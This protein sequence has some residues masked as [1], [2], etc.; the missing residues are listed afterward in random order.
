MLRNPEN[1]LVIC[2]RILDHHSWEFAPEIVFSAVSLLPLFFHFLSSNIFLKFHQ[3]F[4]RNSLLQQATDPLML[5]SFDDWIVR[6]RSSVFEASALKCAKS[7]LLFLFRIPR[8]KALILHSI[9]WPVS[10]N[11][12]SIWV[13]VESIFLQVQLRVPYFFSSPGPRNVQ[14]LCENPCSEFEIQISEFFLFIRCHWTLTW[15]WFYLQYPQVQHFVLARMTQVLE[16][17][18][19][20]L[21]R[22]SINYKG[23][24]EQVR[25][26]PLWHF[27]F[28][29]ALY[30]P[31]FSRCFYPI[32]HFG[33]FWTLWPVTFHNV[34][35]DG[36]PIFLGQNNI[37]RVFWRRFH[38]NTEGV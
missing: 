3:N 9:G 2:F 14:C 21:N 17:I 37:V 34:K 6:N 1:L 35:N 24:F 33:V 15:R 11:R 38:K 26:Y 32:W 10:L 28:F 19:L 8:H 36:P 13:A 30:F 27:G 31:L 23:G 4:R 7:L 22:F 18:L 5:S 25:F 12:S 20:E 29:W 16:N